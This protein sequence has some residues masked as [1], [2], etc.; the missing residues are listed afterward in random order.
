[1]QQQR[2]FIARSLAQQADV[3]F[4]DEPFA[5][6]DISTEKAIVSLLKEMTASGKTVVVVHH[7]IYSA[8]DYFDWI[9]LLNMHLVASGPTEKVL[10]DALL[11]KTYGGKL[12]LLSDVGELIKKSR[13]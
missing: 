4:M 10:T 7:D 9:I 3:Y 1:G 8:S 13:T 2:V 12:S 11:Q 5:G 6:V